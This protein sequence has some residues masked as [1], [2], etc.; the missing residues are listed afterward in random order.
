MPQN[1]DDDDDADD[2]DCPFVMRRKIPRTACSWHR[3]GGESSEACCQ[4]TLLKVCK[5]LPCYIIFPLTIQKYM[6]GTNNGLKMAAVTFQL[7][8][9]NNQCLLVHINVSE[10]NF[11]KFCLCK[12]QSKCE[13]CLFKNE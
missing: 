8:V 6:D 10:M 7:L 5:S 2:D 9:F 1:N 12:F 4:R 11:L 3:R 13:N